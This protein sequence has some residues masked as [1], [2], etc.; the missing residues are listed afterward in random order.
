MSH[1]GVVIALTIP[2]LLEK[3]KLYC[4]IL[5][6]RFSGCSGM[7]ATMQ[8]VEQGTGKRRGP[9]IHRNLYHVYSEK[10]LRKAGESMGFLMVMLIIMIFPLRLLQQARKKGYTSKRAS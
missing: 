2:A 8:R 5:L 3:S 6:G 7:R 10:N 1:L 9:V 4:H